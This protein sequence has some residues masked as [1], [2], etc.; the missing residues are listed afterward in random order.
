MVTLTCHKPFLEIVLHLDVQHGR[1]ITV[2][3]ALFSSFPEPIM[4][5]FAFTGAHPRAVQRSESHA[6]PQPQQQ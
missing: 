5:A 1:I 6:E 4:L 2:C 3:N